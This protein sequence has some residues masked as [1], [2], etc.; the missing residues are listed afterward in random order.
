MTAMDRFPEIF[1]RF[2]IDGENNNVEG[3]AWALLP[4]QE[5]ISLLKAALTETLPNLIIV[6]PQLAAYYL[7]DEIRSELFFTAGCAGL[8][9]LIIIIIF[10]RRLSAL[11]LVP[12]PMVMGIITMAGVMGL[13]G[14]KINLFNFIV[15]PI[16]I[17]IGLD[18]G[19]H[20]YRR[21]Q[22]LNDIEKTLSSTG[23]SILLTTL[24]TIC[25]FGSLS[26]ARYHV[27]KE[28]G[29]M[30]IVGVVSSF[31]F[32]IMVLPAILK[33]RGSIKKGNCSAT[34]LR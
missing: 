5:E 17:G 18:D 21:N 19:I 2:F 27:L 10:F 29:L 9:V 11:F 22:E 30:V 4:G 33:L 3:V 26:L 13:L 31:I 8:L 16:L 34:D 28:M 6:N 7:L 12:L 1:G 20:I 32:S 15:L 24:T 14:I 25:G 23:R